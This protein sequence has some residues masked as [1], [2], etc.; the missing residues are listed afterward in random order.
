M[1]FSGDRA[2][3][4]G[5]TFGPSGIA[6]LT[7]LYEL[8]MLQVYHAHGMEG[9]AVLD[10]YARRLPPT[11][12]FLLACGLADAL[13]YLETLRFGSDDL[14]F[15][16]GFGLFGD[17]FLKWLERFRF[18]GAVYAVPEGTPVFAGEPLLEV[19]AR[20]PEARH[21]RLLVPEVGVQD[22]EGGET[23]LTFELIFERMPEVERP[24]DGRG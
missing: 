16:S 15:L 10:L 2:G 24:R 7:D 23:T 21:L 14:D 22:L 13:E 11:R 3:P 6:L 18:T 12:A 4:S 19:V 9:E 20:L 17:D 1:R 8:T 5:E